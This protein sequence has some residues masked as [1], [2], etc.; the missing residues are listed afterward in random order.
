MHRIVEAFEYRVL[1]QALGFTGIEK[2][3]V[4]GFELD[5]VLVLVDNGLLVTG[6]FNIPYWR[7]FWGNM[8]LPKIDFFRPLNFYQVFFFQ[9][10]ELQSLAGFASVYSDNTKE[11]M[12]HFD[13]F[14]FATVL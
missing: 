12:S 13:L 4:T 6:A 7:M 9:R 5:V 14:D 3:P 1:F 2:G 8:L 10:V 11:K